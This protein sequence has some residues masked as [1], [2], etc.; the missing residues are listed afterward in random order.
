MQRPTH[1]KV[2][3]SATV[4][5]EESH[6]TGRRKFMGFVSAVPRVGCATSV[7]LCTACFAGVCGC[8]S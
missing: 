3:C 7:G 5:M 2:P 4:S 1:T 8:A 6:S